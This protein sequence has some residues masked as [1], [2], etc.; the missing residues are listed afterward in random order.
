[1]QSLPQ[2]EPALAMAREAVVDNLL[3]LR[4]LARHDWETALR[5]TLLEIRVSC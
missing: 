2:K 5:Q 1:M 4:R 3:E